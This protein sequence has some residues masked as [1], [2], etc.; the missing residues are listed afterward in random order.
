MSQSR[1]SQSRL[2]PR[3]LSAPLRRVLGALL[4]A[5]AI[6]AVVT[7]C[8]SDDSLEQSGPTREYLSLIHI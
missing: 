6:I 8:S 3:G 5:V 4:A 2:F 1:V 7:A